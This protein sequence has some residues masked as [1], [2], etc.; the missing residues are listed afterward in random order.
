MIIQHKHS[1]LIRITREC[2]HY[3]ETGTGETIIITSFSNYDELAGDT[4]E[5]EIKVIKNNKIYEKLSDE[6]K[7]EID[8]IIRKKHYN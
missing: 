8:E 3:F 2:D 5:L 7:E 1:D 4:G 6:A